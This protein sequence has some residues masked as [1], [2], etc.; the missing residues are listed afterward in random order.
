MA[1]RSVGSFRLAKGNSG[2]KYSIIDSPD[3]ALLQVVLEPGENFVAE[4]GAMVAKDVSID[5][6]TSLRGGLLGA[7]KRKFLGGE[8][9]FQNTFRARAPGQ[10]LFLSAGAE[11]DLRAQKLAIGESFF[12]QSG[13]YV[14]HFG[15]ELQIDTKFGGVRGFFS[16]VGL[17][18]LR[19]QGPGTVFYGSYG[20]IH[21]VDL[22]GETY[23]VDT[24]HI[25]GFTQTLDYRVR[26]FGGFKGLFLS[27]EGLVADFQGTGT[28]YVQTRNA[29][30]L[31]AFLHPF[32]RVKPKAGN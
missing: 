9:L 3:F 22:Q 2:M 16:G 5:I 10:R 18:M 24:G 13:A 4:S 20:A 15:D 12:L 27:G 19:I 1:A 8:S 7:A 21:Q 11:G 26:A 30:G 14:G 29:A 28:V 17:F 31:A 23:T 6:E 32:R 25:V